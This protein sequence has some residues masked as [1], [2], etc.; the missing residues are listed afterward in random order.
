VPK[1]TARLIVKPPH[2][3]P[4]PQRGYLTTYHGVKEI[5][6][7]GGDII[8]QSGCCPSVGPAFVLGLLGQ[9]VETGEAG[10]G[11]QTPFASEA[12]NLP[13]DRTGPG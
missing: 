5:W 6:L 4:Q 12:N 3:H 2:L 7:Y 11:F 1:V 9:R 10:L 13:D 8:W